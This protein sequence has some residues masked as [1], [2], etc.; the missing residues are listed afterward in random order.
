MAIWC[1]QL[2]VVCSLQHQTY[3]WEKP[4]LWRRSN[5]GPNRVF[6]WRQNNLYLFCHFWGR[7]PKLCGKLF[8]IVLMY[9]LG[10][11]FFYL[12]IFHRKTTP[13]N[14]PLGGI[15][16]WFPCL[17]PTSSGSGLKCFSSAI[18]RYLLSNACLLFKQSCC[19]FF[20]QHNEFSGHCALLVWDGCHDHAEN[21]A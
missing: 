8:V 20:P 15:T 6:W 2:M 9:L 17:T 18:Y 7:L 19:I 5:G 16:F 3:W 13:S 11:C 12:H 21:S 10:S 14:G 1:E 4:K